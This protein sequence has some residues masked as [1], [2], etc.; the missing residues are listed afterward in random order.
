MRRRDVL[1]ALLATLALPSVLP[2]HLVLSA[3]HER[4]IK[5]GKR[6]NIILI[7]ADDLGYCELGCN[8]NRFNETPHLDRLACEG[9]RF[10]D[11]YASAAV[12]SPTRAALM[13]GQ[14]PARQGI[15]DYLVKYDEH[16]LSPAYITIN[17]RLKSA[18][19]A[20][21]LIGKWHLTGDYEKNRGAPGLHNWDEVILSETRYIASGAYF[22]PY[23]FMPEVEPREP[24]E[25][26]TDRLNTEAIDFIHRHKDEPFF[27]YLS[28]YAVHKNLAAKPEMI[29]KYAL[30]PGVANSGND[31]VLAAMLESID[32][33]VGRIL[34]TLK[35]LGLDDDTLVVFTSDNGGEAINTPLRTGKTTL[36][37]GGIR[38]PLVMRYP[39]GIRAGS[40]SHTPVVTHDFYPTFMELADAHARD[41]QPVDGLSLTPLFNGHD[42]LSRDALYWHYPLAKPRALGGRS[43]GA[44]RAGDYKLI[45]FFDSGE[46]ELYNLREDIG[47]THDLA[48]AMPDTVEALRATLG[49]W[50]IRVDASMEPMR[51]LAMSEPG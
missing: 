1:K 18:G 27:L 30:K 22:A 20:T 36:Y 47:E 12:C 14:H 21:G 33:G 9:L 32:D 3:V 45:E 49:A 48:I 17:E 31:P 38:V 44:V 39:A 35:Q 29:A 10:T 2:P 5:P 26:L 19:Y 46:L 23:F 24:Q 7:L 8:G 4:T 28:H 50:R 25:Y 6:P 11:A 40:I 43:S 42:T 51:T 34:Q 13:T 37:E 41:S 16:Y 15:T